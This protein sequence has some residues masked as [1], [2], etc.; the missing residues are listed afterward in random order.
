MS[1]KAF[2]SLIIIAGSFFMSLCGQGSKQSRLPEITSESEEGFHDL[3]LAIEDHKKL[4]DGAQRILG[5][6]MYKGRKVSLVINL[7][8]AWRSSAPD[9]DVPITTFQGAVSFHSVGAESDLLLQAMDELYG[10]KQSPKAMNKATEFSAISLQG[11]PRDL[12]KEMVKI[13]LF[14]ESNSEDQYAEL[15]TNIDLNARK[16]Y[17]NEKDEG[18]RAAIV[19]A[20]Q[21]R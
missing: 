1:M 8:P 11:D 7:G 14:F 17:I 19:R 4:P 3:V 6:G 5:S 12:T 13:K 9:A 2:A 20:L 10:T 18:Y 21:A 15:F 16:V